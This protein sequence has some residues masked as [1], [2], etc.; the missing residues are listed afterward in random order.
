MGLHFDQVCCHCQIIL[1]THHYTPTHYA[2]TE[3][4]HRTLCAEHIDISLLCFFSIFLGFD[5]L[6]HIYIRLC[7]GKSNT[8]S[9]VL[10]SI[11]FSVQC[12]VY[13][14]FV[15]FL[16]MNFF[17]CYFYTFSMSECVP[18]SLLKLLHL[19]KALV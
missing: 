15:L 11:H 16:G 18:T 5:C 14:M 12:S 13:A 10:A 7:P 19:S 6:L 9:K 8:F 4:S 1:F 3:Q 17:L 2:N